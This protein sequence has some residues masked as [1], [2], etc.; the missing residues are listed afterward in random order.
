MKVIIVRHAQTDENVKQVT[1]GQGI[2]SSLNEEGINQAKKLGQH[3]KR[4]T[5]T[6]AYVSPLERA[7]HT[8]REILAHHPSAQLIKAPHLKEQNLGIYEGKGKEDW[9]EVK[10]NS[11]E[12]FHLF[13]PEG[14]ESYEDL[15][16]RVKIFFSGL[17]D[18]HEN[19][20]LLLVSHAG[21]LG[22]LYLHLFDKPLTEENYK[23][24]KPKNTAFTILEIFSAR[25]GSAAGGKAYSIKIHKIN[26]LEH[27][28]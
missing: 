5:I 14:G 19:D 12:P 6:Y 13:K 23:S 15:Q 11:K 22:M 1:Q 2:D 24:H 17:V 27:L 9:K 26:S 20:T 16:E 4:E 10:K 18:M 28:S 21:T 7:V 3:L 8:A 25:G